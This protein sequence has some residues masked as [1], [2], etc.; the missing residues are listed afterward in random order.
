MINNKT[1]VIY[2]FHIYNQNVEYFLNNAI[3]KDDYVD[4]LIICNSVS[5]KLSLPSSIKDYVRVL[6]RENIGYD[7]GGWSD[8]ILTNDLYK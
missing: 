4:F 6:Q 7:F 1:L 8:G 3:F 2:V 5:L